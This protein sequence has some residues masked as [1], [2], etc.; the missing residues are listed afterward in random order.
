[1]HY[2]YKFISG[3]LYT[4]CFLYIAY[5]ILIAAL[6]GGCLQRHTQVWYLVPGHSASRWQNQYLKPSRWPPK[7]L[8]LTTTQSASPGKR[9][10]MAGIEERG[11]AHTCWKKRCNRSARWRPL[12]T[13]SSRCSK[14]SRTFWEAVSSSR[15]RASRAWARRSWRRGAVL[16]RGPESHLVSHFLPHV[17]SHL[18]LSA[19]LPELQH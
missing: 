4:K 1:M 10:T 15:S 6:Q 18:P 2:F 7:F 19:F 12:S 17:S 8:L 14:I 5:I 11:C 16:R 13:C 3:R 9:K